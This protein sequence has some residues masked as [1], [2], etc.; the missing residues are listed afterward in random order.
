MTAGTGFDTDAFH[1][2]D[3]TLRDGSQGEGMSFSVE[4][5]LAV[6]RLLD[7]L[8]VGFIE[9]GW[10]GASPKDT[11][12][13]R[14]AQTDLA[15]ET[16]VLVA[17]GA[18][19]KAGTTA[20]VDPQVAALLDSEAKAITLVAKSSM[21]HV[22]DAL[23]TSRDEAIAMVND[24]VALL[25][26][27]GRRVFVD[28]EHAFD[29]YT[30]DAA[31]TADVVRAAHEAGASAIVLCDTNG[32]TLPWRVAEVTRELLAAVPGARLGIHCHDDTG[33]G[34]A[35]TLS[36]VEAGATHVQGA[37]NG[38]GERCGNADL[39][40]VI[41]GLAAKTGR[42]VL[43]PGRL[44]ELTRVSHAV[45]AVANRPPRRQAPYVGASAF[46]HKAGL[47]ASALKVHA[48][49]YQ[50]M[51]PAAVGNDMRLLVSE[52]A[53]RATIELK[54]RELGLDLSSRP[55][56]VASVTDQVKDLESRGW[57]FEA[58][59]A[60]FELL[61]RGAL[62]GERPSAWDTTSWRVSVGPEG[63]EATVK[64]VVKGEP[65]LAAGEGNGPVDALDHALRGALE[66]TYPRLA[67]LELVDYAVRILEDAH[68]TGAVTRVLVTTSDGDRTWTTVGVDAN[69]VSAS[70][71]AISDAYTYGLADL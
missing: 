29:G 19:R 21:R 42:A 20:D 69:V 9:A 49:L 66:K 58:A 46:A 12:V 18:T 10:P 5:K 53:G 63:A 16:A 14:R 57:S 32:G 54:G 37:L 39:V 1:V 40:S 34:V 15:L 33:C 62:T 44:Q 43:P 8:G 50:H 25:V 70:W 28:A 23:R 24:T 41:G 7:E 68:G 2:Y 45:A 13:F 61:L 38:Y 30:L 47:H 51:D 31:F 60:S 22:S 48:D 71:Q 65:V 36:A 56:V 26:R 6:A 59:E 67:T 4:D 52:L 17:F 27:E 11:E 35:N 64:L 3:T 55:D